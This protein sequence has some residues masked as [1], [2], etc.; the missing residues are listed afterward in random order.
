[1]AER[2]KKQS[3][4]D[5]IRTEDELRTAAPA[6]EALHT[7]TATPASQ[8]PFAFVNGLFQPK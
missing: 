6:R 1:M 3:K 7:V 4:W 2:K 8:C 5:V